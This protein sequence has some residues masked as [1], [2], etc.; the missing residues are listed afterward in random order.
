MNS[1]QAEQMLGY[2]ALIH[3]ELTGLRSDF[4]EFRAYGTQNIDAITGTLGYSITD[5]A[6]KLDEIEG[7]LAMIDIN[8]SV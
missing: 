2:L 3:T 5:L 8:T 6:G 1:L 7:K 4:D